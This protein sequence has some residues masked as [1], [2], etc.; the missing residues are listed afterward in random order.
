MKFLLI[1]AALAIATNA[2]TIRHQ[3][4][5]FDTLMSSFQK[6]LDESRPVAPVR[7]ISL[8]RSA[9]AVMGVTDTDRI[10]KKCSPLLEKLNR[11]AVEIMSLLAMNRWMEALPLMYGVS[12]H[13]SEMME[14]VQ[15]VGESEQVGDWWRCICNHLCK[16]RSHLFLAL[17][18]AF[19]MQWQAVQDELNIVWKIA[20]DMRNC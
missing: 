14:C 12:S 2:T 15:T 8:P 19:K 11:N 16:A 5:A 13:L 1:I 7:D 17:D 4:A 3:N 9:A 18:H 6:V 10:M 20:Y